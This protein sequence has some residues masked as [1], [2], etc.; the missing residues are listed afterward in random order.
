MFI[1]GCGAQSNAYACCSCMSSVVCLPVTFL[2]LAAL[3]TVAGGDTCKVRTKRDSK[4]ALVQ[5]HK[6]N[7]NISCPAMHTPLNSPRP[8][9]LSLTCGVDHLKLLSG[10][11][12]V[13]ILV[14]MPA[15]LLCGEGGERDTKQ[16]SP[17]SVSQCVGA[18]CERQPS[19]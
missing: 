16:K 8:C 12:T 2:S 9:C 17:K 1:C 15:Q 11:F 5:T 14:R 13:G 6:P 3:R 18:A 10:L 4:H 19:G 7:A